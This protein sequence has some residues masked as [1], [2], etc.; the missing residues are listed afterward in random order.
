M[1]LGGFLGIGGVGVCI[2]D[3]G[4][5]FLVGVLAQ[6]QE[7]AEWSKASGNGPDKIRIWGTPPKPSVTKRTACATL[8]L[9]L[10]HFFQSISR[11]LE[12]CHGYEVRPNR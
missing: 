12:I 2:W 7:M 10:H 1:E 6:T 9:S 5:L 3:F 11:H 8:P 4:R